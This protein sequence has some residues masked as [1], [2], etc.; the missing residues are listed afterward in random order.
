MLTRRGFVAGTAGL[1]ASSSGA[2]VIPPSAFVSVSGT[3]FLNGGKPYRFA[4]TNLWYAPYLGSQGKLGHRERLKRELDVLKRNGLSNLR[5]LASGEESPLD[6]SLKPAIHGPKPPYNEELLQGLDFTLAEMAGRGMKAVLFLNNFWEWSGGMVTYQAWTNGGHF[7]NLNDPAHPWPE[8]A[9][10]SAGF[11]VSPKAIALYEEYI[12]AIIA[13]VNTVT[14]KA[15]RDD[16]TIMS[17]QIANEPRPGGTPSKEK[18]AAFYAFL[19]RTAAFIK[20]RDPNHLVSTGNEG[21][22]GCLEST[23][24]VLKAHAPKAIDYVTFHMWPQNWSWI[25][26]LKLDTSYESG[27]AKCRAYINTHIKLAE[28]L[29]KPL[30][31]EEFGFPREENRNGPEALTTHRDRFFAMVYKAVE[32]S[33]K[34]G[35]PLAGSNFWAWGGEGQALHPDYVMKPGDTTYVGD[36]PQ[37]PQ[38]R[39]SVFASDGSTLKIIAAHAKALAKI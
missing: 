30:V 1:C 6:N 31:L 38:G 25:D 37:E 4:G 13:R 22:M 2:A 10:F 26:P 24:C 21:V 29:K 23:E 3:G 32:E 27:E 9:D 28:T 33:A 39:N 35:G 8:F 14:G 36:P 12:A 16:P 15:Y 18:F 5:I 17:W 34:K 11:Y 19:A 7:I 20:A